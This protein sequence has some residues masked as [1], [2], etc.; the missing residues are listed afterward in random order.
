[1]SGKLSDESDG[2][3]NVKEVTY[4]KKSGDWPDG[5]EKN[6]KEKPR[7]RMPVSRL[8]NSEI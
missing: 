7:P 8:S 1:M 5:T 2:N 6:Q 4:S 3:I